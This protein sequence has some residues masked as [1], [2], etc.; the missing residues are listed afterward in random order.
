MFS[1]NIQ[2]NLQG[3]LNSHDD[4]AH[5]GSQEVHLNFY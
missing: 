2:I 1:S 5:S 4:T 3:D